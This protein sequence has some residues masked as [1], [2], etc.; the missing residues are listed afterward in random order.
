MAANIHELHPDQAELLLVAAGAA[1][2]GFSAA[3]AAE[4]IVD[5]LVLARWRAARDKYHASGNDPGV[6]HH[7]RSTVQI[8][9]KRSTGLFIDRPNV[10]SVACVLACLVAV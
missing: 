9:V 4:R 2:A 3:G 6:H 7:L 1:A 10:F 5:A 8:V